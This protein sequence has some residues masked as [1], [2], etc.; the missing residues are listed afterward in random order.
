MKNK[1]S[2]SALALTAFLLSTN[3]I[4]AQ[5]IIDIGEVVNQQGNSFI[6]SFS[7]IS[8]V[9]LIG[10]FIWRLN[11]FTDKNGDWK[12]GLVYIVG[13]IVLVGIVLL[14]GSSL[15]SISI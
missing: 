3:K 9:G 2:K 5:Q 13:Y 12:K 6:K 15:R 11:D 7:V 10:I 1:L 8:I 14:V 4:F